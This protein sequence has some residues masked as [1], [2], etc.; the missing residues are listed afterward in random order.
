MTHY[1]DIRL[2]PDPE[3]AP[4]LLMGALYAKLHRALVAQQ[5]DD[6][7]TS[8]PG[9][10]LAGRGEDGKRQ[11]ATLGLCLRLHGSHAAL[12]ALMAS[13]WL[14]GMRDHIAVG[15]VLAVPA[16]AAQL[17]VQR[18]QAK[19][20]PARERERLMRRKGL[21]AADAQQR[22]PDHA[23]ERLDLPYLTLYSHSTGQRFRLFIA[24]QPAAQAATG[25]FNSYG[26]SA[27]ATVAAC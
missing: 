7:G 10:A 25:V 9:Y 23:A 11:P 6:I 19:S 15:T 3:F 5:S 27:T 21:S 22:I 13:D 4:A 24:Q 20:S 16:G 17:R 2:L 8:F 12:T 18:K 26:F 14:S 1:L